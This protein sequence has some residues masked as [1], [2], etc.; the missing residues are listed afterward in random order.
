MVLRHS[1]RHC[2]DSALGRPAVN[3]QIGRIRRRN[4]LLGQISYTV[5][6]TYPGEPAMTLTF[7]GSEYG[8]PVVMVSPTGSQMFVTD[9]GRF[10]TFGPEW[11]RRFFGNNE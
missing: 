1:R 4:G 7:V 11:V 2:R 9:P 10:G 3:P 6:V 5:N 8:G